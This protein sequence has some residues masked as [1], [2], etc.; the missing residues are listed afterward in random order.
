MADSSCEPVTVSCVVV[1][2]DRIAANG[3]VANKIGTYTLACWPGATGCPST[4]P[5]RR[6]RSIRL[7][8]RGCDPD[9][10]A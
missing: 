5:R 4:L 6:R 3:D 8:E 7:P 1:G 2:A 9:R 10:D